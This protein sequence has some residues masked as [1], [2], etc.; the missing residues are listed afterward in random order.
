MDALDISEEVLKIARQNAE[1]NG[2]SGSI[3]FMQTDF[4]TDSG[5]T[6][7]RYDLIISNPLYT[8]G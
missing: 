1:L 5:F 3:R 7:S 2:V 4:L 8:T 6:D